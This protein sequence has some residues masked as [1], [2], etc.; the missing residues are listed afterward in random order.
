MVTPTDSTANDTA[1]DQFQSITASTCPTPLTHTAAASSG[2]HETD[3]P[4]G[5]RT[6]GMYGTNV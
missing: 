4:E 6:N 5:Y 2:S 3:Q 1:Q